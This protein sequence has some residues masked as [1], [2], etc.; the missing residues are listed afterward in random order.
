MIRTAVVRY[1]DTRWQTRVFI[2]LACMLTVQISVAVVLF[3]E[4]GMG[5]SWIDCSL[6]HL[7]M[8]GPD[9]PTTHGHLVAKVGT[10]FLEGLIL[11]AIGGLLVTHAS[12]R[13]AVVGMTL[14]AAT[15]EPLRRPFLVLGGPAA[16]SSLWAVLILYAYL[17]WRRTDG[18]WNAVLLGALAGAGVALSTDL[19][20]VP[21][22]LGLAYVLRPLVRHRRSL[23]A[24]LVIVGGFF[25][26]LTSQ[27]RGL[28]IL[29]SISG[30]APSILAIILVLSGTIIPQLSPVSGQGS[31]LITAATGAGLDG[32]PHGQ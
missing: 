14:F 2:I 24:A 30:H 32:Q 5:R 1:I 19:A 7:A 28:A 10:V 27:D 4:S 26:L 17:E 16:P 23:I 18:R 29:P 9:A 6:A 20:P 13:A 31:E 12:F 22:G 21:L 11:L 25:L 8:L 15:P 3:S